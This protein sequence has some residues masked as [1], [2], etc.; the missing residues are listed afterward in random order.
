MEQYSDIHIMVVDDQRLVREGFKKLLEL[1]SPHIL[2]DAVC[3]N[4]S[5]ALQ[6]IA[7][8]ETRSQIPN[9]ALLDIQMP[10]MGGIEA[11]QLI[12]ARWP[13]IKIILL[14]TFDDDDLIMAGLRAGAVGYLLKDCAPDD[15]VAAIYAV[16]HG[17][18]SLLP[19]IAAKVVRRAIQN[20]APVRAET[21][22]S[23]ELTG[24]EKDIL[25]WLGKGA[26]NREISE[27]LFITEGT[28][29]NHVSNILAKLGLRDRTQA[30]LY[31]REHGI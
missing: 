17:E 2:V 14:T 7:D 30:A 25:R 8:M 19:A 15:L 21:T 5:E 27:T 3:A 16:Y 23:T 18:T 10:V 12:V 28:V 31:A 6:I 1:T 24:R 11:A 9:I 29:K 22:V 13:S 26:S 4:G 20:G